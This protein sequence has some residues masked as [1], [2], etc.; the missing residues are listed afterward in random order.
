V[1]DEHL[2]RNGYRR[3]IVATTASLTNAPFLLQGTAML[4]MV[5][6]R[7]AERLRVA[8]G[9]RLLELPLEVPPLAERL[10]WNPRF[11]QSQPHIWMREQIASIAATL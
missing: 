5:P 3:N 10:V 1:A 7:L 11:T 6:R 2:L 9:I 4:A 8:A